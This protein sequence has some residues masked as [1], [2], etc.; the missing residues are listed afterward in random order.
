[1]NKKPF[2]AILIAFFFCLIVTVPQMSNCQTTG[3]LT[4]V[5]NS[6]SDS[7]TS[8]TL[9]NVF[10][11]TPTITGTGD[12]FVSATLYING[13][14]TSAVNSTAIANGVANTIS[15]DFTSNEICTWN[16][17]LANSNGSASAT[18]D[19]TLTVSVPSPTPTAT[20]TATAT[21][22]T[23]AAATAAPTATPSATTRPT[24]TPRRAT[25]TPTL[26]ATPTEEANQ[27]NGLDL[28]LIIGI[29]VIVAAVAG[30]SGFFILKKR[31][32]G[33]NEK[34][35][36][37]YP[38]GKFQ[39]WVIKK[40]NGRPGD[41]SSGIDGY[42]E[43]GQ[44]LSI[45]QADN[46]TL[47]EV[48]DFAALLARGNAQK[49]T[50]VAFS[51]EN[52]AMEGKMKALD[53]GIELEMLSIYELTNKNFSGKIRDLA[54][55]QVA[56]DALSA[57]P[58]EDQEMQPY[59]E[60]PNEPQIPGMKKPLVFISYSDTKIVDQAKKLLDFLHYEYVVGDK[61]EATIPIPE[62]KF[63][64]MKNCDC[65][66]INISAGEQER[67]YSGIYVLNSNVITEISGAY[68]KYNTQVVLLVERKVQLPSNLQGLKRIDYVDDELS[69]NAAME[70]QKTLA[71]FKKI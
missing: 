3:F 70:L 57:Y 40:F 21:A 67:R 14:A 10:T 11:Y 50:I 29:V 66:I 59:G 12:Y 52:D 42:T 47:A 60:L 2:L 46:V 34:T 4:V 27:E 28:W 22:T 16:V 32:G 51:Y 69:F 33:G 18:A 23:A 54:R 19:F 9:T 7:S 39:D 44:P 13:S 41:P 38:N 25:P 5:L 26:E 24:P 62:N 8:T 20:P 61:E 36:R 71:E 58:A 63:G 53:R 56:F 30:A 65:A 1:M 68:L 48:D 37:R 31:G 15:Y 55:T 64:L 43:G 45:K 6:P 49:G 17:L 35:L